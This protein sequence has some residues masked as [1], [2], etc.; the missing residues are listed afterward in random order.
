MARTTA[1][2]GVDINDTMAD[3]DVELA[4]LRS[5]LVSE[6]VTF[7]D[8]KAQNNNADTYV[9]LYHAFDGRTVGRIPFYMVDTAEGY[10]RL[11]ETFSAD[12]VRNANADKSWI[13]KRVWYTTPQPRPN[14]NGK[15]R[16]PFSVFQTEEERRR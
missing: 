8:L 2:A 6:G 14:A 5:A 11:R 4:H 7:T 15:Y 9:T 13:G 1:P 12:D 3:A 10:S 16:C